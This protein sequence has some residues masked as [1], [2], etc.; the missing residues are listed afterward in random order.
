MRNALSAAAASTSCRLLALQPPSS[1]LRFGILTST[2]R[3][4]L[5]TQHHLLGEAE[6]VRWHGERPFAEAWYEVSQVD[7]HDDTT[8][9]HLHQA[10]LLGVCKMR[11]AHPQCPEQT[12]RA[13]A[14]LSDCIAY[15]T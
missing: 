3:G 6:A 13:H 11:K 10:R 15:E 7:G 2:S 8:I 4:A 12:D 14:E 1:E 9:C 5:R